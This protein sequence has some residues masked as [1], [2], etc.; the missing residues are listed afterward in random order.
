MTKGTQR[1]A[2]ALQIDD[3][4][5]GPAIDRI[6]AFGNQRYDFDDEGEMEKTMMRLIR[7]AMT[8]AIVALDDLMQTENPK[9][10]RSYGSLV[11]QPARAANWAST[12]SG[13]RTVFGATPG[14]YDR[15]K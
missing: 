13:L 5:L 1:R 7:S 2:I 11:L 10:E 3:K 6:L 9:N 8:E 4:I 14:D 15:L 12:R